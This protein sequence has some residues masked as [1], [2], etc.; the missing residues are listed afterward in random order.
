[1]LAPFQ[2]FLGH[3]TIDTLVTIEALVTKRRRLAGPSGLSTEVLYP[4]LPVVS[5]CDITNGFGSYILHPI[6]LNSFDI[7]MAH[8][9]YGPDPL[10]FHVSPFQVVLHG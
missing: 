4:E 3:E 10:V 5:Y 8:E 7:S 1:M 2:L 6:S 9:V